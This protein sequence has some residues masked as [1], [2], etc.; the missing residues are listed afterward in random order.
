LA[1]CMR[2][3]RVDD[4]AR[5]RDSLEEVAREAVDL[6][7]FQTGVGTRALLELAGEVAMAGAL[8]QRV[9]AATVVARGP[10]PLTALLRAGLRVDRRT[11]DP[12]TTTQLLELLEAEDLAGSRVALQHYGSANSA[13][14]DFLQQRGAR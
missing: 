6:F 7:I 8:E 9:Q 11:Q 14:V 13:L 5:L 4:L 2:E 3:V 1:P 12:H 10:K